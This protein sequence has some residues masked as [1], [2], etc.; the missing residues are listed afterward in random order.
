MIQ[1]FKIV[2]EIDRG[3]FYNQW[4]QLAAETGR[5]TRSAD[6]PLSLKPKMDRLEGMRHF[7]NRVVETWNQLPKCNEQC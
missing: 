1:T 2:R 5:D 4:F 3:E 6:V 7:S